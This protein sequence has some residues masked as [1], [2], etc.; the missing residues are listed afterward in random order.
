MKAGLAIGKE[1]LPNEVLRNADSGPAFR[2]EL[3]D[4]IAAVRIDYDHIDD[5]LALWYWQPDA[6]YD[7]QTA[8]QEGI[9]A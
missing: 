8:Y 5:C 1:L 3:F 9:H 7:G 2:G 6:G 4:H